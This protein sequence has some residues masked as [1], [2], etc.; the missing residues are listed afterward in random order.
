MNP[1]VLLG[2]QSFLI[3]LQM[4][5]A[6]LS[7]VEHAPAWIPLVVAAFIGGCQFFL[8]HVGNQFTPPAESKAQV[9]SLPTVKGGG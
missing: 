6:G 4:L 1:T 2:L 3:T 9:A 5:S 7:A 8:Q